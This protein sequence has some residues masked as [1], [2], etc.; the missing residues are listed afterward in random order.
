MNCSEYSLIYLK[1]KHK[2]DIHRWKLENRMKVLDYNK[3]YYR[4]NK[5]NGKWN[6][7]PKVILDKQKVKKKPVNTLK[8]K[9]KKEKKQD[10]AEQIQLEPYLVRTYGEFIIR[11]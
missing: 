3:E 6:Y 2:E 8:E 7:K 11:F 1:D 10:T 5:H 9:Q 4:K